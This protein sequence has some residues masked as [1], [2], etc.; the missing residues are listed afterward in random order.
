M[1]I[2]HYAI[3]VKYILFYMEHAN[4]ESFWDA[5]NK[6]LPVHCS[7]GASCC[8]CVLTLQVMLEST[9]NKLSKKKDSLATIL[10]Q[11]KS[12]GGV[13]KI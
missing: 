1:I 2:L 10:F 11:L 3:K 9:L 12:F 5:Q 4:Q 7:S 6:Y 8:A 13:Y